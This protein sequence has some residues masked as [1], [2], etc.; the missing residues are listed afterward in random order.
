MPVEMRMEA[1]VVATA[2]KS[3]TSINVMLVRETK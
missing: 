1:A 2:T 3:N